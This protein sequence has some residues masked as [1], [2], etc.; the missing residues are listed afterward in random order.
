MIFEWMQSEKARKNNK[1]P[2]QVQ[3]P[4]VINM[5]TTPKKSDDD[6]AIVDHMLNRI[7]HP[8]LKF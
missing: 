2:K 3:N 5:G 4:V 8:T 1:Q 6:K 7:G